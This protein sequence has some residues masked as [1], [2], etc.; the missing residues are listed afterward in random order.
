MLRDER[1]TEGLDAG[2]FNQALTWVAL[3]RLD[4]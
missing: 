3:K 2:F 4:C 1:L